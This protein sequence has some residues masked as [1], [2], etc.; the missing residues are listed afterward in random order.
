[1]TE[2]RPAGRRVDQLRPFE[3]ALGIQRSAAGSVLVSTGGT[4]VICSVSV[5]HRVP[6]W[7]RDKGQGWV[8]AEYA[9]L[10]GSGSER[11]RR[12]NSSRG[13]EIQR[14]IGRSLRSVVDLQALDGFTLTAD[15]DVLEADGGTRTASITGAWVALRLACNQLLAEKRLTRDPIREQVA[16][17]SVGIVGGV[18]MLDLDYLEDRDADVDMNVVATSSGGLVEVQGTAEGAPFDPVALDRLLDL[19]LSGIGEL[20]ELQREAIRP[21]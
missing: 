4:R 20:C 10:P 11:V 3:A 17:I 16:A 15:C 6:A 19:A 7:L 8:T 14:L 18:P 9:M 5:E 2:R 1:M 21:A 12:G 13:T